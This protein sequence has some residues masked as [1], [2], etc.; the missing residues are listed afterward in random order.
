MLRRMGGWLL[1]FLMLPVWAHA[2][3]LRSDFDNSGSVDFSDFLLFA[4]AFGSSDA[5]FDLGGNGLVDFE[6]FLVFASEFGKSTSSDSASPAQV[7]PAWEE[8]GIEVVTLSEIIHPVMSHA[9]I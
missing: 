7:I 5:Q 8:E 3:A 1:V 2:Q 9:E 4:G 6:D